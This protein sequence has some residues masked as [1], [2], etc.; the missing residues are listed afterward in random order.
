MTL[1]EATVPLIDKVNEDS[2]TEFLSSSQ[3]Y[4]RTPTNQGGPVYVKP[5]Q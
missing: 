2:I 4:N 5:R 3:T 1:Y